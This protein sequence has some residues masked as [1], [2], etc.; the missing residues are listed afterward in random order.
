ILQPLGI[1]VR[2]LT[3]RIGE[4][5]RTRTLDELASGAAAVAVGTHAL[6]QSKVVFDDLALVVVDEQHRFGVHQRLSLSEKGPYSDLLVMTAT[7]IPRTLVLA[8]FGDMDVSRLTDKPAGRSEVET[9]AVP[10]NKVET[11]IERLSTALARGEKA[12]WVCPLVEDSDTIDLEAATSRHAALEKR[13]GKGRVGL[14]HGKTATADRERIME[15]FRGGRIAVLVATTVVEVGVDVPDATIMVVE[16]AERFGLS[17]LH[18]LRGRVGRGAKASTCLLLYK[19]P[20]G[21]VAQKRLET[22]RATTDG[23]RIAEDDLKLRGEGEVLGTRQSGSANFRFADLDQHGDLLRAAVDDARLIVAMDRDLKGERG[24][25]L[26]ALLTL[27][28]RRKAI[29]RLRAG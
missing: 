27:F 10:L 8:Q 22:M 25:A 13:L 5:E 29:E 17:Q 20:L 7:P 26:R 11:V 19:P 28:E 6:F 24:A 23:F 1:G 16:H 4:A 18:Q 9:R 15:D 3:G 12:Y 2:L 14:I 21:T